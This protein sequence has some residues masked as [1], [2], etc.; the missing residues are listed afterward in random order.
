MQSPPRQTASFDSWEKHV[1]MIKHFE[2]LK[3][4]CNLF[5]INQLN[6]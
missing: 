1:K 5:Q 4:I 3:F 2:M 6:A